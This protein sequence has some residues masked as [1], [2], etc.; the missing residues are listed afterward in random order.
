M[1]DATTL[2][3]LLTQRDTAGARWQAAVTELQSSWT[4]LSGIDLALK[5]GRVNTSATTVQTFGTSIDA[6]K[7]AMQHG[8]YPTAITGS[9][10]NEANARRD[11]IVGGFA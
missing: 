7:L 11:S 1:S 8:A 4:D 10:S 2:A 6:F 9:W 5:N 3:G